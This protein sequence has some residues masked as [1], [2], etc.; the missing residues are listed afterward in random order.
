M[1]K[2]KTVVRERWID[3]RYP[4]IDQLVWVWYFAG[5]VKAVW[6]GARWQTPTKLVLDG[7]THWREI[8]N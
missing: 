7:V 6:T 5:E 2:T 3:D 4:A 1:P 8:S